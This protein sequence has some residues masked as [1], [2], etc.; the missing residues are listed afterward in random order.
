[1]K[2]CTRTQTL[3]EH[4]TVKLQPARGCRVPPFRGPRITCKIALSTIL[5]LLACFTSMAA[6]S[7]ARQAANPP[8][9]NPGTAD[10]T[11]THVL[12]P[13]F[14]DTSLDSKKCKP[15][16]EVV[17]K[18]AGTVRLT[19]KEIVA[20]GTKIVG[21][22]TEAKARSGSETESSLGIVFDKI[23]LPDGKTLSIAGVVRAVA[24]NPNPA[25]SGGDVTYA[26]IAQ[27]ITHSTPSAGGSPSVVPILT[28]DSVGAQGIKNLQLGP[29]GVFRSSGRTV[30]LETGTQIILR[31][32]LT[33][34]D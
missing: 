15:G 9:K 8:S 16:A 7:S 19:N 33:G 14:L 5:L 27:T 22:A 10:Q 25:E 21:H 20:R 29:D 31:V 2:N 6:K 30:K 34:G 1:M 28:V 18:T 23:V 32:Q 26:D 11:A 13:A 24:P 12:I 4:D 17:V 3:G